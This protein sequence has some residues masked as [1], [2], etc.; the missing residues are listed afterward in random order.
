MNYLKS[1]SP[2]T[3]NVKDAEF[4][5][6]NMRGTERTLLQQQARC[7][8]IKQKYVDSISMLEDLKEREDLEKRANK[9][10]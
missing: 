9:L 4:I 6:T 7:N 8:E 2:Q 1:M 5:E 3:W 10:S